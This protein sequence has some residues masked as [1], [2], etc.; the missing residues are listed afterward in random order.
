MRGV[1]RHR[2]D[3]AVVFE[4]AESLPSS[5]SVH[6]WTRRAALRAG[7][8]ASALGVAGYATAGVGRADVPVAVA[9]HDRRFPQAEAF[10]GRAREM[11]TP[12]LSFAQD[13]TRLWFEEVS[14]R[15]GD[16]GAP[17]IGLTDARA[18]FCFEQL[19]WD[20]GMRVRLRIDHLQRKARF[21]HV[22]ATPLPPVTLAQLHAAGE[23]F[24]GCSADATLESRPVWGDC[25]HV[26][27]QHGATEGDR[28]VTWAIAP[29]RSA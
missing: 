20:R 2:S 25:T 6:L 12:S 29:L 7:V 27:S 4:P 18:L 11:G 17:I 22:S 9:I 16:T 13:M 5:A 14:P 8:V 1:R 28:L 10:A 23:A 15:L 3:V 21:V 24:G 26:S 19:A